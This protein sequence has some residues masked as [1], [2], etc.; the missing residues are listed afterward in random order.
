[1]RVVRIRAVVSL[2][3]DDRYRQLLIDGRQDADVEAM[4]LDEIDAE[5][6][7]RSRRVDLERVYTAELDDGSSLSV[8]CGDHFF[9]KLSL[10]VSEGPGPTSEGTGAKG[11]WAIE[12]ALEQLRTLGHPGRPGWSSGLVEALRSRGVETSDDEVNAQ[13][14]ELDVADDAMNAL[15]RLYAGF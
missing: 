9:G 15:R 8:D 1:M 7:T 4:T 3:P 5:V 6:E 13:G 12:N 10:G 14:V 11:N 2:L